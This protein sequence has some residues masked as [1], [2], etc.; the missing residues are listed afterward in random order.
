M[1]I[2]LFGFTIGKKSTSDEIEKNIREE[3]FV[4]PDEYDG[5]QSLQ[6]GGFL[7]TYVDFTGG[8]QD[9]NQFIQTYRSLSLYPEVDLAIEDIVNDSIIMGTDR[10]PIKLDL[11]QTQLSENMKNKIYAEYETILKMFDFS[12]RAYEIFR[13]WYIDG[14]LYF[15][16]II[17]KENPRAGIK[18]ARPVDPTK[19]KKVRKVEKKPFTKGHAAVPI[20]TKTEEFFLYI[21]NDKKSQQYTGNTGVKISND[22]IAYVHSG[23]I[24]STTKQVV[25]YLQKAIRPTNMLR[26][27]EDAVVIYRISRAPERRIFYIDVG[28]LPKQ[29]AEQYLKELMNRYRNKLVYNQQTGEV[30]DDRNH[31]HMLEDFWLPRREGG[32]GTEISTLQGGQN[33]GE[34]SDVEYLQ[35]KLYRALNVPLS[36]LETQNGFNMGRSAEIT[37]DEAKFYKFVSRLRFKFATILTDVLKKQLLLKGVINE[38]DW[39]DISDTLTFV[40]NEDSY[41]AELRETEILKERMGLLGSVEPYIGRY[42]STEYIRKNILKQSEEDIKLI[43]AQNAEEQEAQ[44][45]MQL[46]QQM[47]QPQPGEEP[48]QEQRS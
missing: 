4:T 1:P 21:D 37:R 20:V 48:A 29:K 9:E 33:L 23:I 45:M 44:Q 22:S 26:Q 19:I 15:H 6:T 39:S 13:R 40:F 8:V 31:L 3:S 38:N 27:I 34:M 5:A 10:K 36:R 11:E 42:F 17:D 41:F 2:D 28:N 14:R 46:Q 18:E 7:G 16:L 25:G 24:D 35:R 30:R 12:H 43:D 32:R 47:Q